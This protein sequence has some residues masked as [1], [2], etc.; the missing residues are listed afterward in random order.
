MAQGEPGDRSHVSEAAQRKEPTARQAQSEG[1]H[2]PTMKT[3]PHG[4]AEHPS[5]AQHLLD[6]GQEKG[7]IA[8]KRR[9]GGICPGAGRNPRS[10]Q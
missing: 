5:Y 3:E 4:G 2:S 10:P 9:E 1:V 6:R 7:L 8:P